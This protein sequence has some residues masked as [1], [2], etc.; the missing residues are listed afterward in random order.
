MP[1]V[2]LAGSY[3]LGALPF[4]VIV[5]RSRGVDIRSVG[6]G[7]P[8]AHNVMRH[9]GLFWGWLVAA[10]DFFKG[11]L[12]VVI[13]RSIGLSEWWQLAAGSASMIGH[14]TSPF[15]NFRGGKGQST[16]FGMLLALYPFGTFIG[17]ILGLSLLGLTKIV[18]LGAFMAAFITFAV[19]LMQTQ[20]TAIVISP[21]VVIGLGLLA[22]L[23]SA[24]KLVRE[25]GGVTAALKAW[26]GGKGDKEKG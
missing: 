7:N 13:A 17:I 15:L 16:G 2:L 19:A 20:P 12:P 11:L 14:I 6:S 4:A 21:W 22:T 25:K 26:R 18:V 23:P 24:L 1:I 8:G 10:F 3:L 9:V 5:A